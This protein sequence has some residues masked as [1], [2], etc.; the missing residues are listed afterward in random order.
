MALGVA[1]SL[2]LVCPVG[3][4]QEVP[5]P[6]P[7]RAAA[8][9]PVI[10]AGYSETVRALHTSVLGQKNPSQRCRTADAR[11]S[12]PVRPRDRRPSRCDR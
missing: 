5:H 6:R 12:R 10:P 11:A 3:A 1:C 7:V 9:R 4:A 2:S 8:A